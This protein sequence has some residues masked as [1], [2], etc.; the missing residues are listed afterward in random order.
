[1][2]GDRKRTIRGTLLQKLSD[3]YH[4]SNSAGGGRS[5]AVSSRVQYVHQAV[6]MNWVAFRRI[7][8]ENACSWFRGNKSLWNNLS[9]SRDSC[10]VC[11]SYMCF[12]MQGWIAISLISIYISN[13]YGRTE[14]EFGGIETKTLIFIPQLHLTAA[15][16]FQ[17]IFSKPQFSIGLGKK[18][19][20]IHVLYFHRTYEK[21]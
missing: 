5:D 19:K 18:K 3:K 4:I 17:I 20:K 15:F 10:Y 13:S 1:M 7:Q 12:G 2:K 8:W 16:C 21:T 6:R 9:M 14:T 11:L